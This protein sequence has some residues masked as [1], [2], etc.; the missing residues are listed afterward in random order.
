MY[1]RE[2]RRHRI[3]WLVVG[4]LLVAGVLL[5]VVFY[6]PVPHAFDFQMAPGSACGAT[7]ENTTYVNGAEV[8]G[9]W[10]VVSASFPA[11]L[12][13]LSNG[14]AGAISYSL[15]TVVYQSS[16]ANGTFSFTGDGGPY[17][18]EAL[19]ATQ[20]HVGCSVAPAVSVEGSWSATTYQ[21]YAGSSPTA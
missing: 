6:L 16:G 20:E 2:R 21:S 1:G 3:V 9:S 10:V 5:G 4:A 12:R 7:F 14:G 13:I 19:P 17:E 8:T 18:Y 15:S 11:E